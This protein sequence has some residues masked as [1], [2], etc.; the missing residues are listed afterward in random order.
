MLIQFYS[1][2]FKTSFWHHSTS[3]YFRILDGFD[4]AF[5]DVRRG[6]SHYGESPGR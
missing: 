4:D 2:S 3:I 5:V 1:L 6:K